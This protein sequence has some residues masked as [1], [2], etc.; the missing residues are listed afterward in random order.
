MEMCN[1]DKKTSMEEVT[2]RA[3]HQKDGL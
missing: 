2:R 3:H 1:L